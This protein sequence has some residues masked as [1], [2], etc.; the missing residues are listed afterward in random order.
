MKKNQFLILPF[1]L[2]V[3]CSQPDAQR[4]VDRSIDFY[5]ME[6][7]QDATLE[8]KFRNFQLRA[9]QGDGKFK[10]ERMFTDSTGKVHDILTNEGFKR[11]VNG[12]EQKLDKKKSDSYTSSVNALFYFVYLPLKLNDPSVNKKYLG[13]TLIKGRPYHKIEVSFDQRGGGED[14]DDIYYYWFDT[15]DYSMDHFAYSTGGNRFR[16]VSRTH[17]VNGIIFQDYIN[18]Q[19][20]LGDSLTPVQHYDSLYSAG[21]L[22]EL[23]RIEIENITVK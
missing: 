1:L 11:T 3:A 7:L 17:D 23:S 4:I 16:S 18:Y 8:F 5:N 15:S 9:T 22:R 2:L 19:S 21:K 13:E 10:Y 20:P 12:Q 14:Y 6:K